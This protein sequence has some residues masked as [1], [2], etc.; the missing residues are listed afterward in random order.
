[1]TR[2]LALVI[3]ACSAPA[4]VPISNAMHHRP[5]AGCDE[6][7]AKLGPIPGATNGGGGPAAREKAL[8]EMCTSERWSQQAIDCVVTADH[9]PLSCLREPYLTAEQ[10]AKWN[11]TFNAWYL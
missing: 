8:A 5:T 2:W 11:A 9:D 10:N 4:P 7:A 1:M 6:L 3:F